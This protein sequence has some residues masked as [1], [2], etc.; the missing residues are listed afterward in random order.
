MDP[1][2]LEAFKARLDGAVSSLVYWEVSLPI[3]GG[4][5]RGDL[6]GPFQ[7]NPFYVSMILNDGIEL[8][9][10]GHESSAWH[11]PKRCS[12]CHMEADVTCPVCWGGREG[13]GS[14]LLVLTLLGHDAL[15][16]Q[17][18]YLYQ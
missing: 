16:A 13:H 14:L 6:K 12:G 8:C 11:C 9:R 10:G 15:E 17:S 4:L 18:L 5:E 7:P 1:S 3:V 2:S